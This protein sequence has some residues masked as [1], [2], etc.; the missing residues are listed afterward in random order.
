MATS[1]RPVL[2]HQGLFLQ[3]QHFQQFDHYVQSLLEPVQTHMKPYFWGVADLEIQE[4]ALQ[5]RMFEVLNAATIFPD[6]TRA[7]FPGNAVLQPRS[8]KD[9]PVETEAGKPFRIYLGLRKFSLSEQNATS[10]D[11]T[12]DL[13]SIATRFVTDVSP[14]LVADLYVGGPAAKTRYLNYVL[15]IFW[16]TEVP[17][18]GNY[19]LVPVAQLELDGDQVRLTR[20][21]IPPAPS[22]S[23]SDPLF[24]ILRDIQ[25]TVRSRCHVLEM[26]KLYQNDSSSDITSSTLRY[27]LALTVINRYVPLLQHLVETPELHPWTAYGFLRQLIGELSTFSD[28]IDSLGKLSDGRALVPGYDHCELGMCFGEAQRLIKELL[29]AIVVGEENIVHL[30]RDGADFTGEIPPDMFGRAA[31][32]FLSV[33]S[34]EDAEAVAGSLAHLAK[35]GTTE[36]MPDMVARSLPGIPIEQMPAAPPGLPDRQ[37]L[38]Y[39]SLSADHPMWGEIKQAGSICLHWGEA[40]EDASVELIISRA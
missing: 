33:T 11:G 21:F 16:E 5:N 27:L 1:K 13:Y 34:A 17:Q 3:P 7:T 14:E 31:R 10:I 23:G 2:W 6:G 9:V 8:F 40:P 22:V 20:S 18:L 26:Y 28:R 4:S 37:G 38:H 39:F 12:E 35:I 29:S 24:R 19:W 25:E 36:F 32:F 15:K 30:V